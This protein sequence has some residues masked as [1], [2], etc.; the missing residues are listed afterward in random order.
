MQT[1]SP[2]D[3]TSSR[4]PS[5]TGTRTRR[6]GTSSRWRRSA[7]TSSRASSGSPVS[8]GTCTRCARGSTASDRG[9]AISPSASTRARTSRSTS[10]SAGVSCR[11]LR[12]GPTA[13]DRAALEAALEALDQD[14]ARSAA[15]RPDAPRRRARVRGR[16]AGSARPSPSIASGRASRPGTSCSRARRGERGPP[17]HLRRRRGAPRPTSPS[18]GFDV[19]YL[20]PIHPIGDDVPQGAEQRAGR[21]RPAM[22]AARGRSAPPRAATRRSI[23]SSA[24]SP[25]ST[26]WSQRARDARH[27]D[28]ARPRLPVLARPSLGDA[29]IPE[30]FRHRPDGTIQYAENP[31]KKYQDIYPFDFESRGL[32]G[33]VGG[34]ARRRR[35]SGSARASRIF[36]V[37]NPHTKPFAFWEWLIGEVKAEHPD[38]IFLA[39]AFTR[40]KVMYRLAKAR[41]H[42]VVHVLHAGA[43]PQCELREYLTELT[44]TARARVLPAE[45][46]AEHARHPDRAPADRR[47]RRRS[48]RGSCWR[49]RCRRATAST[50][51]R[52]SSASIAPLRPGQRGV[53]RLGEVPAART[54]TSTT[55]TACAA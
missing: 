31:P 9:A 13:A 54:G 27:R 8:A 12:N 6:H 49:R 11:P 16:A 46:L 32:A 48:S 26:G 44:T 43:T 15:G 53:P 50:G 20:P 3:T 22:S 37:D 38:M 41:L 36:R 14:G 7:T 47:P 19:L 34:A 55:P 10:R 33:A 5:S 21:P 4:A 40:P 52:S 51:R 23:P 17:R 18:M 2:T 28:R 39:E 1:R 24:R 29:S 35:A 42:P 30:W 25:T 45:L